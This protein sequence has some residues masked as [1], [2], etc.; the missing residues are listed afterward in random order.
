MQSTYQQQVGAPAGL[1]FRNFDPSSPAEQYKMLKAFDM[2]ISNH[3]FNASNT[4]FLVRTLA[5]GLGCAW[6]LLHQHY[7][8]VFAGM[9]SALPGEPHLS[10]QVCCFQRKIAHS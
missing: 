9:L 10:V 1:Y 8:T 3:M 6:V 5:E 4:A 7:F 2:V